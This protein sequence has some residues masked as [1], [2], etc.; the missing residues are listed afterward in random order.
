ANNENK[1]NYSVKAVW[2]APFT[3]GLIFLV[4]L[5]ALFAFSLFFGALL[6]IFPFALIFLRNF[7]ILK[8]I[9]EKA[10]AIGDYFLKINMLLLRAS[11]I[12][13]SPATS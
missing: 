4:N 13:P 2:I 11:G 1:K 9:G 8:W 12:V 3:I 5:V 6:I 10:Q 7:G